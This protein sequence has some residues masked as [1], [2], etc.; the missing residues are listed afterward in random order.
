VRLFA[1]RET[2]HFTIE[3]GRSHGRATAGAHAFL[4]RPVGRPPAAAPGPPRQSTD[5][6]PAHGGDAMG[7]AV[8]RGPGDDLGTHEEPGP[9]PAALHARS[10]KICIQ[11]ADRM[12]ATDRQAPP[13]GPQQPTAELRLPV[14]RPRSSGVRCTV[15]L[16]LP[17]ARTG[18]RP[19]AEV[20][21]HRFPVRKLRFGLFTLSWLASL[22]PGPRN[23]A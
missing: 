9:R 4:N 23:R 22:T 8:G 11:A 14:V 10:S 2:G 15:P 6:R 1:L 5:A 21:A 12:P 19:A 18:R 13:T 7:N 3:R 17:S 16:R 20:R